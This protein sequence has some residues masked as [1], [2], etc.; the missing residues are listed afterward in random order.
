MEFGRAWVI[1]QI[2]T[3]KDE[4]FLSLIELEDPVGE[5]VVSELGYGVVAA[6]EREAG[7]AAVGWAVA[8]GEGEGDVG[9]GPA[10]EGAV[11][12]GVGGG[13]GLGMRRR[14]EGGGEYN[15]KE[16][17]RE[18]RRRRHFWV[19]SVKSEK[20]YLDIDWK[21]KVG[22]FFERWTVFFLFPPSENSSL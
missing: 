11:A 4:G 19:Q 15:E 7:E 1:V 13:G 22:E 14:Q 12:V 21:P 6:G 8:A 10:W 5:R 9:D 20:A 2:R 3:G 16:V 17:A 18:R